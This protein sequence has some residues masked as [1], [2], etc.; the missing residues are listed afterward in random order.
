MELKDIDILQH[1]PQE[2][3]A[4]FETDGI[5]RL[6]L[7]NLIATFSLTRSKSGDLANRIE[8][9]ARKDKKTKKSTFFADIFET[10]TTYSANRMESWTSKETKNN[11][12]E[13][14]NNPE[15][16]PKNNPDNNFETPA[17][18]GANSVTETERTIYRLRLT[19][20]WLEWQRDARAARFDFNFIETLEDARLIRFYELTK[21]LRAQSTDNGKNKLPDKLEIEYDKFISLMPLPQLRS[22][23][24][25]NAQIKFLI[26][27]LKASGYVKSFILDADWRGVTAADR[28]VFRFRD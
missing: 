3:F 16:N 8:K 19:K 26:K 27:P 24:E 10:Y 7:D 20:Y 14:F 25:I 28:L 18:S 9:I 15:I 2:K 6:F 23:R 22:D 5:Q 17:E 21:L 12:E 1:L 11:D 13:D 4:I